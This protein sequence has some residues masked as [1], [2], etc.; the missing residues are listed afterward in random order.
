MFESVITEVWAS[1][2]SIC[3]LFSTM[4]RPQYEGHS[5]AVV[6][7]LSTHTSQFENHWDV[8]TIAV[9]LKQVEASREAGGC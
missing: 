6:L 3:L 4:H 5:D 2:C 1:L 9:E 7:I 8:S